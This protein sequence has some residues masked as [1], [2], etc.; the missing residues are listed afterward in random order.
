MAL[1]FTSEFVGDTN[2][3]I[4]QVYKHANGTGYTIQC[5]ESTVKVSEHQT[6]TESQADDFAED[7]VQ[8]YSAEE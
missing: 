4:A 7:W 2:K 8:E 3:R 1:I 6:Q 5:F